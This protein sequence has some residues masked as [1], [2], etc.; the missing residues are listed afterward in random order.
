MRR[1]T[2]PR[3]RNK[4]SRLDKPAWCEVSD[5][6]PLGGRTA[7]HGKA[8]HVLLAGNTVVGMCCVHYSLIRSDLPTGWVV[9]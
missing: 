3:R 5:I 2:V 9:L 4:A 6:D 8:T 1:P 7:C